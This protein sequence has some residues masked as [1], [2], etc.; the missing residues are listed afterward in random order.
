MSDLT[1]LQDRLVTSKEVDLVFDKTL[2]RLGESIMTEVMVN[3]VGSA[4]VVPDAQELVD[5]LIQLWNS[6]KK[7]NTFG[8][9]LSFLLNCID[10]LVNLVEDLIPAG[11]DKKA[12]VLSYLN[13]IYEKIVYPALPMWLKPFSFAIRSFIIDVLASVVIDFIVKKYNDIGWKTNKVEV[14]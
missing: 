6:S 12:T 10:E 2:N 3:P 14:V 5:K 4:K 9:A 1:V 11:V 7:T 13:A 8:T